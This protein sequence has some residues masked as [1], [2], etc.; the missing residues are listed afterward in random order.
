MTDLNRTTAK[1]P[2]AYPIRSVHLGLGNFFR[3]HQAWYSDVAARAGEPHGI[4]A[5][6]GRRPDAA[7]PLTAQD[8][9]YTLLTRGPE[10]DTAEI[11]GSISA[12]HDGAD[13]AALQ[14]Y[15]A[16]PAVTTVTLTI[17]EAGYRRG[18][19]GVDLH[20]DAVAADL[21]AFWADRQAAVTTAPGRLLAGLDARRRADAGP[22]AVIPCDNL[23]GN[24]EA[25][26]DVVLT[27]AEAVD[28][29]LR[30]WIDGSVAF[31]STMVDR[32]TPRTVT[33]DLATAAT[34]TGLADAA[35]V[36]TEPFTEW[37]L[38][39]VFTA[40]RPAWDTA[41]ARF[42]ADV[43]PFEL[44]KL[45]LLNGAHSTLAY[46]GLARG[47]STV[48]EAMADQECV[49]MMND[50]W[51]ASVIHLPLPAEEI[52][53]YRAALADRFGNPRMQHLLAQIAGDGSQK[54]PERIAPVLLGERTAGRLPASAVATLAGW[55]TYLRAGDVQDP[56]A[57]R[58]V[59]GVSGPVP[60]AAAFVVRTLEPELVDDSELIGAVA[61]AVAG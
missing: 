16:D 53:D 3:A 5:F 27:L 8:G 59:E 14:G 12:A 4:A 10:A 49:A 26:R 57:E 36:V 19:E 56:I 15:L 33:A 22:I 23:S 58:L 38:A 21:Q 61:A 32:I 29:A 2:A 1:T 11:V 60:G 54:L 45:W 31:V 51:D 24:G 44:R 25:C 39:D 52:A 41:G 50:W 13:V 37:V 7:R 30:K 17:T 6:T 18:D 46:V 55:L 28:P 9:L 43:E 35:P 48:A 20:D 47:L 34:L 40:D 42:V